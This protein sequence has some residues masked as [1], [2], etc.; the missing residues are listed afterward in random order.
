[1]LTNIRDEQSPRYILS[2]L[3]GNNVLSNTVLLCPAHHTNVLL[4]LEIV[5]PIFIGSPSWLKL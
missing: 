5:S 2:I 1:M 3:M 4:L